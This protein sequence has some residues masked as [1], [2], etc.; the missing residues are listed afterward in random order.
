MR[1]RKAFSFLN[2]MYHT[3]RSMENE[4]TFLYFAYGSNL[5]TDRIHLNNP[6]AV[7]KGPALLEG[8]KL[9]FNFGS[10]VSIMV[11]LPH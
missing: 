7:A 6:S 5:S 4:K 9:N 10:N 8:Y 2:A 3:S 11:Y 1:L